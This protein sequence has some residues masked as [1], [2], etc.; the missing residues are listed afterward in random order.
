MFLQTYLTKN[1]YRLCILK[2]NNGTEDMSV[3]AVFSLDS[4]DIHYSLGL[5][6]PCP[7]NRPIVLYIKR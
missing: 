2:Q 4:S 3:Q 6:K 1:I 5:R 7:G